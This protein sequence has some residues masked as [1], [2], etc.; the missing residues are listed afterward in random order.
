MKKYENRH[1]A[2]GLCFF[3]LMPSVPWHLFF[4]QEGGVSEWPES[5]FWIT[6][7]PFTCC[8]FMGCPFMGGPFMGGP[9]GGG[10]ATD[11]A[12]VMAL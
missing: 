11:L 10:L 4:S 12:P 6:G 3:L 9:F 8:P 5:S 1:G 7:G 2:G